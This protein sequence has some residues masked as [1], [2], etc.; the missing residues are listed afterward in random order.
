MRGVGEEWQGF[1]GLIVVEG[2]GLLVDVDG[3]SDLSREP[4][5][6][7][8]QDLGVIQCVTMTGGR[9]MFHDGRPSSHVTSH[10]HRKRL[11]DM[12]ETSGYVS[13]LV[14]E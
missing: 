4:L 10:Y 7:P 9:G 1:L 13:N 5:F 2:R 12:I 6:L 8:H 14:S 3:F 11:C